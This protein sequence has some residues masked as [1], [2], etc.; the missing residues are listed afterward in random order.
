MGGDTMTRVRILLLRTVAITTALLALACAVLQ[1]TLSEQFTFN[2]RTG[3]TWGIT[4]VGMFDRSLA[5]DWAP[6]T[7]FRPKWAGQ[8]NGYGFRYNVY[9]NGNGYAYAPLWAVGAAVGAVAVASG[10]IGWKWRG[11]RDPAFP[12][13]PTSNSGPRQ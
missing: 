7:P 5:V 3:A 1:F 12:V 6:R 8:I 9:S 13:E 4:G 11:S 10:L 2:A